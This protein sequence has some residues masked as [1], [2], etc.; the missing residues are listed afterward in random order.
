MKKSELNPKLAQIKKY[1]DKIE[2][3]F[4]TIPNGMQDIILQQHYE[5]CSLNHCIR[6]GNTAIDELIEMSPKLL[7]EYNENYE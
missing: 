3:I 7:K 6:W 4:N 1:F 5:D 2:G